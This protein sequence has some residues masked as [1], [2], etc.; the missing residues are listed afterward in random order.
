[1]IPVSFEDPQMVDVLLAVI[2]QRQVDPPVEDKTLRPG[3]KWRNLHTARKCVL[4]MDRGQS[5]VIRFEEDH[6]YYARDKEAFL[7]HWFCLD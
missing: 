6:D 7:E 1:M 3:S 2:A 4:I 5:I